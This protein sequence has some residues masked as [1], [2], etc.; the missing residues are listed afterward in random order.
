MKNIQALR[1][2]KTKITT[3]V[4]ESRDF[5][6]HRFPYR[7]KTK[8]VEVSILEWIESHHVNVTNTS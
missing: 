1:S 2:V 8:I 5:Q 4:L 7:I 3:I 6:H